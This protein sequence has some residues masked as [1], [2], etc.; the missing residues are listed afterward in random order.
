M[1]RVYSHTYL[2]IFDKSRTKL[3]L[4]KFVEQHLFVFDDVFDEYT[5]NES[6]YERTALPLVKYVFAGGKATC[7]A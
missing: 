4:T 6:I 7:F 1:Q 2:T 3:D 5:G